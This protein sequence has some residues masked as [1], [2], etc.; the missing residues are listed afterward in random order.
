[1]RLK[2]IR[3]VGALGLAMTFALASMGACGKKDDDKTTAAGTSSNGSTE[4]P[5]K[6]EVVNWDMF[7][8]M[9]GAE[10]DDGN[11]IQEIIAEKTGVKVKETWL[12]GQTAAEAVGTLIAGD[13]LPVFIDGGDGMAQLY[14]EEC[15][16]AWDDYLDKYPNLKGMYTDEEWNMFRQADGKIYWAN[17]FQNTKNASKGTV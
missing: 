9:P 3:K 4:A 8:A 7:I 16:I 10:I 13:D 6:K 1:M 15:L 5:E 17:V 12:T 2:S 14:D 11:E